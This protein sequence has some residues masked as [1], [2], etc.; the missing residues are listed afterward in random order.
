MKL[1]VPIIFLAASIV[2]APFLWFGLQGMVETE[3][4]ADS[5]QL[6]ALRDEIA[7]LNRRVDEL[8]SRVD[9][10]DSRSSLALSE[11]AETYS[12][13]NVTA[14]DSLK[15]S[16]AQVVLIANRRNVNAGL[17]T[18]TPAYLEKLLGLP[19]EDLGDDC[20]EATNE[21]LLELLT[22]EDVGPINVR[23]LRP[24]LISL[25]QVFRNV[26]I[27]EPELY[28]R[29]RSAGSLCV[30][31]VRGADDLKASAHAYGLAVDLNIDGELDTLGDGKSQLGLI[32]LAEFFNKERWIWGAGFGREDSMH[33]EVSEEKI[34]EWVRLGQI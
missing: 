28:A 12:D 22:L 8:A 5:A 2:S 34:E 4:P 19:R 18:P 27:Y 7:G 14:S 33:F 1:N 15:D 16:F 21:R 11:Q 9:G 6:Q 23:M 13:G 20:A 24:A 10:I 3:A 30:R 29:I 25:K 31:R 17:S 26:E 32:L